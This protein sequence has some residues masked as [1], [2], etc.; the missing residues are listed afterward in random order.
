MIIKG[1]GDIYI[2]FITSYWVCDLPHRWIL[3]V[4]D[5]MNRF[6]NVEKIAKMYR[7]EYLDNLEEFIHNC[8]SNNLEYFV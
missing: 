5:Q 1:K 2:T 8:I 4:V 6:N 7:K 3:T